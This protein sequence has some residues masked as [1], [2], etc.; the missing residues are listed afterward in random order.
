MY[1]EHGTPT[2]SCAGR[3][4]EG[5]GPLLVADGRTAVGETTVAGTG[6]LA[7]SSTRLVVRLG[8]ST[9][10][11][12]PRPHPVTAYCRSGSRRFTSRFSVAQARSRAALAISA[13]ETESGVSSDARKTLPSVAVIVAVHAVHVQAAL[14]AMLSRNAHPRLVFE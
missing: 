8:V 14:A 10:Y 6:V 1:A 4:Q 11:T 9:R 13:D 5:A 12:T 2:H 3:A 7:T